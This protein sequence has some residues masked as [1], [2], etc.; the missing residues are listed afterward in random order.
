MGS[1]I[2]IPGARA[3]GSAPHEERRAF[4]RYPADLEAPCRTLAGTR[5]DA[6]R[7]RVFNISTAGVGL[8][9][10]GRC[11]PGTVL[12]I[13]L[14]GA[15]ADGPKTLLARVI[16]ATPGPGGTWLVGGSFLRRLDGEA[17]Q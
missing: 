10:D 12:A 13:D 5:A 2:G 15:A 8:V 14:S 16:H 3:G 17:L 6:W 1:P 9:L 7:A 11:E 4:R